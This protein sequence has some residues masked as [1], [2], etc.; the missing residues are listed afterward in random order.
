MTIEQER[1]MLEC[2]AKAC[3]IYGVD[4]VSDDDLWS[5]GSR[6]YE[7][8]D[9]IKH[10][11]NRGMRLLCGIWNPRTNPSDTAEMCAEIG[12]CT[13]FFDG[14]QKVSCGFLSQ[15]DKPTLAHIEPY[16]DSRLKAWMHAATL[17]CARIGGYKDEL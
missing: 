10:I 5:D 4:P 12:I 13:L 8:D 17:V 15:E 3:G 2:A 6:I 14:E 7:D 9:G 1:K 16:G 11:E